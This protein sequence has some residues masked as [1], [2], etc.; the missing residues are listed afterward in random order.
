MSNALGD[1]SR[2]MGRK[3]MPNQGSC[4]RHRVRWGGTA[5]LGSAEDGGR[6]VGHD[7]RVGSAGCLRATRGGR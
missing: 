4:T 7:L 6:C 3:I 2:G 5:V 1:R